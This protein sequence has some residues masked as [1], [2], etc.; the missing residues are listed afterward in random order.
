MT[1]FYFLFALM[2]LI[3]GLTWIAIKTGVDA[4]PPFF[5]AATRILVAGV[6]LFA[7][8]RARGVMRSPRGHTGRIVLAGLLVNTVTYGCLFWGMQYVP[9]GNLGGRQPRAD[10]CRLFVMA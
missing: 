10:P 6:I 8:A 9:S 1:R 7:I 3:W 2:S 4:V 5:F